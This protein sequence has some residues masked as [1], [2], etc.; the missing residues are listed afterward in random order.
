MIFINS[1]IFFTSFQPFTQRQN[2]FQFG[3]N[4]FLL[5][6]G[7]D[8]DEIIF[9]NLKWRNILNCRAFTTASGVLFQ[10]KIKKG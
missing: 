5:S 3:N 10:Y 1:S 4:T 6:K 9:K 2:F 8:R 7:W